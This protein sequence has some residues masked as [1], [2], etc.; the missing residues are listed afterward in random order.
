PWLE[1]TGRK[2]EEELGNGWIEGVHPEDRQSCLKTYTWAFDAR[3]PFVMEYRLRRHDGEYRWV[4]DTG[5]QRHD[6][7]GRFVGY[8]GS[9]VDVTERK[10]A[11]QTAREFGG[12]LLRAQ[13]AE[14]ARLARELHDDITQRLAR[15]AIDAGRLESGR[16]EA[17][18]SQTMREVRDGL[19]HLSE[20]VHSLSYKLHPS[21]LED[22]GLADALKAECERFS[23]HESVGVETKLEDVPARI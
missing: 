5:Q 15:L 7:Q 19:V 20:D 10:K 12:L 8:I 16:D 4:S 11:E 22:L 9:C 21:L 18:R 2:L 1:F 14:R 17:G 13:E 23:R 3:Q 6:S